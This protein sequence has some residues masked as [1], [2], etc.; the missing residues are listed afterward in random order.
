[1]PEHAVPDAAEF[2]RLAEEVF[3]AG[4]PLETAGQ[5]VSLAAAEIEVSHVGLQMVRGNEITTVAATTDIPVAVADLRC[6]GPYHDEAWRRHL[7]VDLQWDQ[8]WPEWTRAA[9]QLGPVHVVM[10]ELTDEGRRVG[11]L[12]FLADEGQHF[13]D[14][15]L[16]FAHIFGRHAA[17]AIQTADQ[18]AHLEV[19]LDG[20]KLIGQAQGILMERYD[21]T[22]AQAFALLRR[23]SQNH[24]IKLR[25][26]ADSLV[27]TRRLPV[28]S[29]TPKSSRTSRASV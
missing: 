15:D 13:S 8:R 12:T 27:R 17:L 5:V 18:R 21:L 2:A 23:L 19:A 11:M 6:D 26:I 10:V 25:D 3:A 16:A 24:N 28:D 29:A 1:M 22:D 4:N 20:R 9:A 7:S 14:D